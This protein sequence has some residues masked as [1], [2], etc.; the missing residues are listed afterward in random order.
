MTA[1]ERLISKYSFNGL[2]M[3]AGNLRWLGVGRA[4][5]ATGHSAAVIIN[6]AIDQIGRGRR[7]KGGDESGPPVD[8]L[9]GGQAT[10]AG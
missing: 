8:Q 7:M 5:R 9:T 4:Q 1:P 6:A 3:A 2:W 10:Q